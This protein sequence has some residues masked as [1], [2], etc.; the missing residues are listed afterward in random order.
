MKKARDFREMSSE[1]LEAEYSEK[2]KELF[3]LRNQFKHDKKLE[4]PHLISHTKR[5]IARLLTVL[6]EKQRVQQ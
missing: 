1:E 3:Q 2:C 6:N 4:K 5:E